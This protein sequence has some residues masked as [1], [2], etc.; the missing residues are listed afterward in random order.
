M[1]PKEVAQLLAAD[2]EP[3]VLLDVREPWEFAICRIEGSLSVPMSQ[4]PAAVSR[5]DPNRETVVICH[6]GI[7]SYQV[8]HYLEQQGFTRLI[9]LDG[10]VAAWAR[11]QDP[12]MQVY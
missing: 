8:A 1:G 2:G 9:N 3:P 6:H 12:A 5:L 10:G 4:I 11:D 7:R